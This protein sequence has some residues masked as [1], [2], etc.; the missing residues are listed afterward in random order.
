MTEFIELKFMDCKVHEIL[1]FE[2][3]KIYGAVLSHPAFPRQRGFTLSAKGNLC[4]R[5]THRDQF[6][7]VFIIKDHP[8]S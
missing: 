5:K 3:G 1:K 2:S 6:T 7:E 8:L 4:W